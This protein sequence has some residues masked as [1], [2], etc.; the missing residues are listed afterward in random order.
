MS[1]TAAIVIAVAVVVV[2]GALAFVTL[3]RRSDVRGAGARRQR[4]APSRRRRARRHAGADR[5][6]RPHRRRRRGRGGRRPQ[7]R[8]PGPDRDRHRPRPWIAARP[9]GDR[10][11]PAAV[12]QPRHRLADGGRHR[13]VL[14][15]IDCRLPVADRHRRLRRQGAGRASYDD[16]APASASGRGSSTRPR[17]APG[18]PPTRADALPK[19]EP[20][21]T[22]TCSSACGRA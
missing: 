19:A 14:G 4:D 7:G 21:Y 20:V 3:A 18:S 12:L 5:G 9:R 13:H 15:G 6:R 8:R 11:Q 17:R 1:T 16:I 22:E 10:R 2:L